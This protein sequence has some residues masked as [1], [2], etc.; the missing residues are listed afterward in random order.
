MFDLVALD[1]E[2]GVLGIQATTG[3]HAA[4]RVAKLLESEHLAPWLEAGNRAQVW[5]WSLRGAR[6]KRKTW[7]LRIDSVGPS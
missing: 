6:G 5:S 2:P 3:D 7:T 4:A 1:G